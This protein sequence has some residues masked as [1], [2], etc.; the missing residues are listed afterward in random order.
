MMSSYAIL[1]ER[2]D[3]LKCGSE[4]KKRS[5]VGTAAPLLG[6]VRFTR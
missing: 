2:L 1:V 5:S 6:G 4:G 3:E